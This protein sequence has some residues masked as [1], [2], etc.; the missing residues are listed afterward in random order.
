M[1][2]TFVYGT[3]LWAAMLQQMG[4]PRVP[5]RLPPPPD[6][7]KFDEQ[8]AVEI[9]REFGASELVGRLFGRPEGGAWTPIQ[10][11]IVRSFSW[12]EVFIKNPALLVFD[13]EVSGPWQVLD[14]R[15]ESD[16]QGIYTAIALRRFEKAPAWVGLVRQNVRERRGY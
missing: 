16:E 2:R 9:L 4:L 6:P 1:A 14:I 5:S 13:L 3:F 7:N 8:M 15:N 11:Q 10:P 12:Y